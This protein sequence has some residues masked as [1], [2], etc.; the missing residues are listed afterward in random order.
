MSKRRLRGRLA[1][2]ALALVAAA[3]SGAGTDEP[4]DDA[5]ATTQAQS[6]EP[7]ETAEAAE[8]SEPEPAPAEESEPEPAP[9]EE[10]DDHDEG[11]EPAGVPAEEPAEV[12]G[13]EIKVGM[14]TTLSG[15]AAYLGEG[16]RDGFRLAFDLDGRYD[17]DLVVEDD[18][19]DPAVGQQLAD[20]MLSRD[21]VDVMTGI[22]F[23]NVAGAVVPQVVSQDTIYLSPNAGPS[24]FAGAQCHE[25]YFVVSW[26]NDNPAEAM[27]QYVVDQGFSSVVALAPN[28]QAGIDSVNGFKRTFGTVSDEI[29]TELGASD[30]AQAIAQIRNADP[31]AVYFF[32]PGGMGI[33]FV[34]QY[35]ASG[36]EIPLFGP[37]FSFD[38]FLVDA[39]GEAALGL[40]NASFWAPDLDVPANEAFVA[41]YR[42]AYGSTPT[43]YAA[44]GFDTGNLL[45][46]ALDANGG[47]PSD[48]VGMRAALREANF[49]SVRGGFEFNSNNHPIQDWYLLEVVEDPVHGDLTNSVVEIILE[50]HADAY[51][52]ECSLGN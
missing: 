46:A 44:Q 41:A 28:Y 24:P 34:Q 9:A 29:Y 8:E 19:R 15:G 30:Y 52:S 21:Q 33:A 35:V 5:S 23:S 51:A 42:D 16:V 37:T 32:Y 12:T 6:A 39:I 38:E 1:A 26:Q 22:I 47:D 13:G 17:L 2:A 40:R 3:C 49:D 31:E 48:I 25:N 4:G 20:R 50:D 18:A 27:G 10:R 11:D 7:L 14:I 36:L 45:I 43:G